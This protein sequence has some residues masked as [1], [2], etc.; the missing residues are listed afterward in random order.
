MSK[1]TTNQQRW[2]SIIKD[3]Q[4]SGLSQAAYCRQHHLSPQRFYAWKH[5]LKEKLNQSPQGK[6]GTFLP[7]AMNNSESSSETMIRIHCQGVDIEVTHNTDP[8]L[9]KKAVQWLG[10][11]S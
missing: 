6:A 9:L 2:Q 4:Q 11:L 7:V 5:K 8:E 3:W 1:L 10:G